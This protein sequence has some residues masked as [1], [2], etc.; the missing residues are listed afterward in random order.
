MEKYHFDRVHCPGWEKL[1]DLG[2][3]SNDPAAPTEKK[4]KKN[5]QEQGGESHA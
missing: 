3:F 4:R 1:P 2:L 5:V